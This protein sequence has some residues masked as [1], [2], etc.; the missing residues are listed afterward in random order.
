MTNQVQLNRPSRRRRL[1]NADLVNV[2]IFEV[3]TRHCRVPTDGMI[4]RL[5]DSRSLALLPEA[6][7]QATGFDQKLLVAVNLI[8]IKLL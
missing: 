7:A 6:T 8:E 4:D 2:K 1:R 3:G 5:L